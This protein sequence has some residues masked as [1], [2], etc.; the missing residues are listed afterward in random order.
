[1]KTRA[2]SGYIYCPSVSYQLEWVGRRHRRID[3]K[4]PGEIDVTRCW[5]FHS[6]GVIARHCR[7]ID[8]GRCSCIKTID[9]L[10]KLRAAD[11]KRRKDQRKY[12]PSQAR[13]HAIAATK[14]P[15]RYVFHCIALSLVVACWTFYADILPQTGEARQCNSIRF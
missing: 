4:R 8:A 7:Q 11:E 3:R 14:I 13:F 15:G 1:M 2:K 10:G 5:A 12:A 6:I 9:A